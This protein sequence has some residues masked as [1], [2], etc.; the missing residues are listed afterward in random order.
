MKFIFRTLIF[1]DVDRAQVIQVPR[2]A[3]SYKTYPRRF[4]PDK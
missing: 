1:K 4:L 3:E 2:P